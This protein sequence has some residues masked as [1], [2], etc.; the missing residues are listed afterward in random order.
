MAMATL[1][2]CL[3]WDRSVARIF[4]DYGERDAALHLRGQGALVV[5]FAIQRA[6]NHSGHILSA[7]PYSPDTCV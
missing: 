3:T 6:S 1:V 4:P 7:E 5:V 2:E